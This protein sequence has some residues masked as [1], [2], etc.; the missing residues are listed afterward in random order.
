VFV[1]VGD[2]LVLKQIKKQFLVG[3]IVISVLVLGG[4]SLTGCTSNNPPDSNPTP[5]PKTGN[6]TQVENWQN[7]LIEEFSN[8]KNSIDSFLN[9]LEKT[10]PK[11]MG[12]IESREQIDKLKKFKLL[13]DT[14]S[15]PGKLILPDLQ[16][17]QNI[18]ELA[19]EGGLDVEE[20]RKIQG[21]LEVSPQDSQIGESSKNSIRTFFVGK[22]KRIE[23]E[24]NRLSSNSAIETDKQIKDLKYKLQQQ[25]K[26]IDEQTKKISEFEKKQ[27]NFEQNQIV[28]FWIWITVTIIFFVA[29]FL[30]NLFL[31]KKQNSRISTVL[32]NKTDASK[33]LIDRQDTQNYQNNLQELQCKVQDLV[34]Q[35]RSLEYTVSYLS[36]LS[37]YQP[38]QPVSRP[39]QPQ[40]HQSWLTQS[41]PILPAS[42]PQNKI[43]V[44]ETSES[45]NQRRASF[46]QSVLL[47]KVSRN[48]G[49][50]WIY[51]E[52]DSEYL[53]PKDEM[54]FNEYNCETLK[55]LFSYNFIGESSRFQVLR[56][57]RVRLI[58]DQTWQL[59]E[60]GELQFY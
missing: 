53:I 37:T 34:A 29:I 57:C 10:D 11:Q 39:L 21:L 9:Q 28:K 1:N 42:I 45:I 14:N 7:K 26:E 22:L 54:V 2:H 52:G 44:A 31:L 49:S 15:P 40:R 38:T 43:E 23:E 24:I 19:K 36:N 30:S 33:P 35:I 13:I 25:Q 55:A 5:S 4:A 6:P 48:Q 46:T 60:K 16:A 12:Q 56:P 8:F 51:K 32:K 50:Y 18:L 3:L 58:S 17:M 47:Q 27:K 20:A 41:N 59:I